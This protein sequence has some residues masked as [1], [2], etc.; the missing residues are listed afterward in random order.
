MNA[1]QAAAFIP[2]SARDAVTRFENTVDRFCL[3]AEACGA[4]VDGVVNNGGVKI[5]REAVEDSHKDPLLQ[6]EDDWF[7]R[8]AK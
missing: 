5:I 3:A 1:K 2:Q 4:S 6:G 7:K 8:E